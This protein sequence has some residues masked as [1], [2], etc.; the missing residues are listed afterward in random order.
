[1]EGNKMAVTTGKICDFSFYVLSH[2]PGGTPSTIYEPFA[3][4]LSLDEAMELFKERNAHSPEHIL[5]LLGVDYTVHKDAAHLYGGRFGVGAVDLI[6]RRNGEIK[7]LEDYKSDEV[8]MNEALI[9]NNAVGKLT[10]FVDEQRNQ[11]VVKET[12]VTEET[13]AE[14]AEL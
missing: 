4:K 14:E 6:K 13:I 8:S 1:M 3:G 2:E 11:T 12:V 7:L 9:C 10:K 5:I